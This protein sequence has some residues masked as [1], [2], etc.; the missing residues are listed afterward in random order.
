MSSLARLLLAWGASVT[1]SDRS[2]SEMLEQLRVDG[3]SVSVGHSAAN[4]PEHPDLV[5][6]SKAVPDNNP[7]LAAARARGIR[8]IHR[9]ELLSE[10]MASRKAV[11]VSGTHGKTTTTA[12][13]AMILVDAGQDPAVMLGGVYE[14]LGGNVRNGH[15]PVFVAEACEAYGSFLSLYPD[16]AIVTNIEPDHLDAETTFE[17][18]RASFRTF[19]ARVPPDQPVIVCAQ[20]PEIEGILPG[21]S[22]RVVSYAL[23][24][25]HIPADW[26]AER[27]GEHWVIRRKD[28][29]VA[30]LR[31]QAPG[32]HNVLNALAAIAAAAELEVAPAAAA[33]SLERFQGVDRRFSIR[34]IAGGVLVVDDYAHHPTEIR[35]TLAAARELIRESNGPPPYGY[36]PG[37]DSRIVA[38]FQPHLYSRTQSFMD[39]FAHAFKDADL[40]FITEIYAAREAPIPGI[41]SA[42]LCDRARSVLPG[43]EIYLVPDLDSLP[44]ALAAK[45]RPGDLALTLGAGDITTLSQP[46]LDSLARPV[47]GAPP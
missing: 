41:N 47:T 10:L 4:L 6:Y 14:P 36:A 26:T 12:M 32:E 17:D 29:R 35:A 25:A 45:A 22:G 31:L 40:I 11:C 3:A 20:S 37:P 30:E 1:G 39:D 19:L 28:V 8:T 16:L 13:L 21:L 34:G 33:A 24:S 43:K 38:A 23:E 15:G 42:A 7:E 9:A 27:V 46:I 2:D 18:I 44:A 5:V